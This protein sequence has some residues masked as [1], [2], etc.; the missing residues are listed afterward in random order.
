[1]AF[2]LIFD[3][4]FSRLLRAWARFCIPDVRKTD[5]TLFRLPIKLMSSESVNRMIS[6]IVASS[7]SALLIA[8]STSE[9]PASFFT[10]SS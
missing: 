8:R 9:C 7:D 5:E 2:F 6:L 1:M 4:S 10:R 3:D